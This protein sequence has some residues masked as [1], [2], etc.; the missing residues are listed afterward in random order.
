MQIVHRAK[1]CWS[2]SCNH[3][4]AALIGLSVILFLYS[5]RIWSVKA[6]LTS[7]EKGR[8]TQYREYLRNDVIMQQKKLYKEYLS[9][10]VG[11]EYKL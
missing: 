5:T 6:R 8:L 10:A 11:A 1:H 2:I 9:A 7:V 3:R 4:T